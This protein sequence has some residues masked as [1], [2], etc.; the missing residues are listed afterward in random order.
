MYVLPQQPSSIARLLDASF[1]LL[2]SGFGNVYAIV[3]ILAGSNIALGFLVSQFI[4]LPAEDAAVT[5][6]EIKQNFPAI[7]AMLF[8]YILCDLVCYGAL[9]F[10]FDNLA[11]QRPDTLT[12]AF[13]VGVTKL[14]VMLAATILY[15]VA[16]LLGSMLLLAPGLILGLS[17][18]FY[19][20]LIVTENLGGYSALKASHNLVWGHWWRTLSV[21]MAPG[22]LVVIFYF[23]VGLIGYGLSDD[24][25]PPGSFGILDVVTNISS[26]LAMTYFYA[27]A[28]V[29]CHDLKLRKSG[30]DLARRLSR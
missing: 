29:L 6:E 11:Q 25:A 16:L 18:S 12:D 30:D 24:E 27:L 10:R 2:G 20:V 13:K 14:P 26:A 22:I 8:A 7:F 28:Y 9:V 21:Y 4:T 19:S 1:R 23:L 17:L 5:P 15:V 3:L